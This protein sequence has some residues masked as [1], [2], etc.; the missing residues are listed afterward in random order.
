MRRYSRWV[1]FILLLLGGC[2]G[3]QPTT[4]DRTIREFD[5]GVGFREREDWDTAIACYSEAIRLDPDYAKACKNRGIAYA[6]K[7]EYDKAI[8][9]YTE[10]IRLKISSAGTRTRVKCST[11]TNCEQKLKGT[12]DA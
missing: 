6:E 1:A 7:G 11:Q 3:Y 5:T 2:G 10:A 9:D 12:E 8:K 4:A